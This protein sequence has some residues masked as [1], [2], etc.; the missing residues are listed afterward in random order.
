MTPRLGL[1]PRGPSQASALHV[2]IVGLG[3]LLQP[4]TGVKR[5][6]CIPQV[7]GKEITDVQD[8]LNEPNPTQGGDLNNPTHDLA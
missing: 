7:Q 4:V 2:G 8:D 1:N 3:C 5:F 6:L